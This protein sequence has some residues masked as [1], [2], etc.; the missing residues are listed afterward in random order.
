[1]PERWQTG[2]VLAAL[3]AVAACDRGRQNEEADYDSVDVEAVTIEVAVDAAGVIEPETT[4]EVKSKAS[5]EILAVHAETGDIVE[6]GT[7]LV[8]VDERAPHN[9]LAE[10]EAALV[11][12]LA[13]RDI[14]ETQLG[15]A[16]TLYESGAMTKSEFEQAELSFATTRAQVVS[17]EVAVENARIALE[18]TEVRAPISGTIIRKTVEP[19]MVITS[20]TN[21]VSEGTVLMSMA[22]LTSVR[23]R[24]LVDETD[25]GKIGVGMPT[26][27]TVGAFPNQ[28]F[29]G[30][31]LK[32]EPQAI[33]ESNVTMFAVLIRIENRNGLLRPGMNADVSIRVAGLESVTAVPTAALRTEGDVAAAA[34]MLGR[35]E[36]EFH[37][38]IMGETLRASDNYGE[39]IEV[40]GR[41][42]E[43]PADVSAERVR[44]L[45]A[46]N[47]AGATLSDEEREFLRPVVELVLADRRFSPPA[48]ED[49]EI[50]LGAYEY[51]GRYWV[52][53]LEDG[54]ITPVWVT[55]GLTDLEYTEIV[56]GLELGDS[57][58]L[59]PS[60]SLYEQQA[61]LREYMQRR[62][63]R[64]S[65][66]GGR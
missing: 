51:G 38:M 35:T 22:D 45:V 53:R 41:L 4:V 66:F 63:S 6:A 19:G 28:P 60:T 15:R 49:G 47:N 31:V 12:T 8:E 18:D 20:P 62:A 44:D 7:L 40:S 65:P 46:R 33:A 23:I 48:G 26:S 2:L 32:I 57:V 11:A 3:V 16:E 59:L 21:A 52:L 50:G 27:V 1:M 24:A 56:A 10:V 17:S 64:D 42:Y 9:H 34:A 55:T 25:I 58:L 61:R 37:S 5:G 54:V 43:L 29:Y 14:A 30:E 39:M 36:A 13:R